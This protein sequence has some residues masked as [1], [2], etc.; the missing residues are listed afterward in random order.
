[1]SRF[2]RRWSARRALLP[3]VLLLLGLPAPALA[4][5]PD[6]GPPDASTLITG[7]SFHVEVWLP[8]ILAAWG[9]R[10]AMH[11]VNAAHPHNP[12]PRFRWHAWLAGIVT[13]VIAL[14]SPIERYDTTLFSVHMV[15]HLLIALVAAPLLV[16]GAPITLLLRVATPKARK[17]WILPALHSR[18]MKVVAN[19]VVTWCLFAIVMWETHFSSLFNAALEDPFVHLLEHGLYLITAMLFWYPVVG[20]DPGP[21]R[22]PHPARV[23]Y[24]GLGMPFGSFLGLAIFSATTVLYPHY[25]TNKLAWGPDA[26]T[27]QAYAGG[28]MWAFGDAVFLI[29]LILA[30]A[31]W[32]RSEEAKAKRIDAQL[33]REAAAGVQRAIDPT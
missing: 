26:L 4:H 5:G 11:R 19:P 13:L 25:A 17:R 12:V 33:D 30:V 23:G 32:L 24:L 1:M 10:L 29:G 18:V 3:L 28:I 20:A 31:V 14:A 2:V 16:M 21:Y 9:Y 6:P 8:L 27:D 7:W 15:Q 22:L